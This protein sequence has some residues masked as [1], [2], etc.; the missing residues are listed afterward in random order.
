[1]CL[2]LVFKCEAKLQ[3]RASCPL[4]SNGG[5]KRWWEKVIE[6]ERVVYVCAVF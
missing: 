3:V 4:G 1:M 6:N 5:T 2:G